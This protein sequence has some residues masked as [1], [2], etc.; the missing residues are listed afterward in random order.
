MDTTGLTRLTDPQLLD[1]VQSLS[2][3]ERAATAKLIAALAE[4]DSRRLHLGL[5]YS[6]M[7]A[8]CT[9]RLRLSESAAYARIEAA[10][11]AARFPLV[12]DLLLDGSITL[13]T[14]SLLAPHLTVETHDD[15]LRAAI[16]KNKRE[17]EMQVAALRP[18]PPTPA[19][20]R[21]LPQPRV[22]PADTA[23]A[24]EVMQSDPAV[25]TDTDLGAVVMKPPV[26]P[27]R[28]A[29]VTPLA[30]E[31]FKMQLTISRETH[32]KLRRAQDLMRHSVPDGDLA[33]IVDRALSLLLEKLE[34]QKSAPVA[35]ASSKRAGRT[36]QTDRT[37]HVPASVARE[38][39]K[40]DGS[41][42]TFVGADGRCSA[43]AW[44]ELHHIV[45]F[46]DG[47]ATDAANLTLRCRAHNQYE[48]EQMLGPWSV[49]EPTIRYSSHFA[50]SRPSSVISAQPPR[51]CYHRSD[52][53]FL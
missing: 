52:Q 24:S 18:L 9:A 42:C 15:V 32:A 1:E 44:L 17:V 14:V 34:K 37:R 53:L 6:S 30:P 43:R 36:A 26:D 38:V 25:L 35:Q 20:V 5:G 29:M 23:S 39:W 16:H 47:G 8:F 4:V 41:R 31:R 7:F 10:R 22:L 27:R 12:L 28:R 48:A 51:A 21:R 40:R 49:R 2:A 19:V 45:T 46:A 11:V 13:T 33:V 50:G 3:R